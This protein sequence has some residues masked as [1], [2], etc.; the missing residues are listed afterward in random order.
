[1]G[2][3]DSS[4]GGTCTRCRLWERTIKLKSDSGIEEDLLNSPIP[5]PNQRR[6]GRQ[7]TN[8]IQAGTNQAPNFAFVGAAAKMPKTQRTTKDP[9]FR[10][11]HVI[12]LT[13][14]N[15]THPAAIAKDPCEPFSTVSNKSN[16]GHEQL[17]SSIVK[18]TQPSTGAYEGTA[19]G[20]LDKQLESTVVEFEDGI[21]SNP[22]SAIANLFSPDSPRLLALETTEFEQRLGIDSSEAAINLPLEC[23][24]REKFVEGAIE[25]CRVS[26]NQN[27]VPFVG[28][29][30]S[31]LL[32]GDPT[33]L[34]NELL[35][36]QIPVSGSIQNDFPLDETWAPPPGHQWAAGGSWQVQNDGVSC[37]T[38][39]CTLI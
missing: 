27:F 32:P 2:S 37:D 26:Q 13:E 19:D 16:V 8:T 7:A 11:S 1:M 12:K 35:D 30:S 29:G 22:L 39:G 28:W 38:E 4:A 10:S 33:A 3:G 6:F 23:I 5:L 14:L 18:Y 34:T 25:V 31:F 20:I 36:I 17:E 21:A 24:S 9:A 15:S